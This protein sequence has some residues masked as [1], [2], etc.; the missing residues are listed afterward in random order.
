MASSG[1]KRRLTVFDSA[2]PALAS[3]PA[4]NRTRDEGDHRSKTAAI[5]HSPPVRSNKNRAFGRDLWFAEAILDANL[6]ANTA[7][8][9]C[10]K[11]VTTRA[12]KRMGQTGTRFRRKQ[13]GRL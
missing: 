12:T 1:C 6:D 5:G 8:V 9:L 7:A 2:S 3:S 4:A 10:N 13:F 11:T